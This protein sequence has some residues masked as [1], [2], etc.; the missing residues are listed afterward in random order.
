MKPPIG[1]TLE[2]IHASTTPRKLEKSKNQAK[3][4]LILAKNHDGANKHLSNKII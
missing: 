3:V 4:G 2:S 1:H